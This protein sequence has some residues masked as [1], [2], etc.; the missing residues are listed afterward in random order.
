M[1]DKIL[2]PSILL[3]LA[4]LEGGAVMCIE[5]I[6]SRLVAPVYGSSLEVWSIVLATSVG[7]L[8]AGYFS[9]GKFTAVKSPMVLLFFLLLSAGAFIYLMP[10]LANLLVSGFDAEN[11]LART[12]TASI[13]L[14]FPPLFLLGS[15]TPLIIFALNDKTE[16]AG[17]TAGKTFAVSTVGGITFTYLTGFYLIPQLGL[18]KTCFL[19]A[20][21]VGVIPFIFL[22]KEKVFI[23]FLV[24]PL[25]FFA[26]WF[27]KDTAVSEDVKIL[28]FSEGLLG[29]LLLIDNHKEFNPKLPIERNLFMNRIG[30]SSVLLDNM[31]NE[32]DYV[33]YILSVGSTLKEKP[34]V[35]VLGLG[36]GTVPRYLENYLNA[37]VDAVELDSRV[38]K[39]ARDYFSLSEN[40]KIIVDDARHYIRTSKR[41][42]DLVIFDLYRG[43][44][45]PSHTLTKEAFMEVQNLLTDSGMCI[46]NF[47]G[48]LN[49][50]N[51]L[52]SRSL[53]AT[54][55]TAGLIVKILPT[56]TDE[57]GRNC[58]FIGTKKNWSFEKPAV[59][60]L[61]DNRPADLQ[62]LIFNEGELDFSDAVV[63]TDDKP[64]LEK[65]NGAASKIW[66]K[67]YYD[68][69]T[70]VLTD[71]GVRLF[72]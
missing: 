54:M 37:N 56:G 31:T 2:S 69:F 49:G 41:K 28:H 6:G 8:A 47:N 16:K 36:G 64:V 61:I 52:P 70:K 43:E 59:Q 22:I 42:Y 51:G 65:L 27:S 57:N 12:F 29:Q 10:S 18:T 34:Y 60:L 26:L 9:G 40:T 46:V 55:Q 13:L 17:K 67:G 30:Q 7:A 32:W 62:E 66:R 53:F 38:G 1:R 5:M 45:P 24:L 19:I 50:A 44:S 4:F 14:L 23:A 20:T 68:R 72:N 63:F 71:K 48:F 25:I 21:L 11:L 33:N 15:T 58:L 39:I 35:L 3:L